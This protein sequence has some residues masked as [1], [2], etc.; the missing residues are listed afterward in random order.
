[1][2]KKSQIKRFKETARELECSEDEEQFDRVVRKLAK[3]DKKRKPK[4]KKKPAK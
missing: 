3:P 2:D 1:V 4:P